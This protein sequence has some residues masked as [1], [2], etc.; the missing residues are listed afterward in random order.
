MKRNWTTLTFLMVLL[1]LLAQGFHRHGKLSP[2]L[3]QTVRSHQ[4]M[5]HRAGDTDDNLTL[6]F[7]QIDGSVT[8]D[9]LATFKARRYAQLDDIAIV[10][11]PL[12]QID[13]FSHFSGVQR[14]EA[15]Q[16]LHAT[17]DTVPNVVDLLAAYQST[18]QHQ[19]YTGKGVVVGLMDVGFD[20]TH[21]TFFT[22]GQYRIGAF[23]D[24]LAP[25][26]GVS[27]NLPVGN[28][29]VTTETLLSKGYATDGLLDH[30]GTHTAG[31]AAG[32]GHDTH[33]RGVAFESDICLVANAVS[34]DTV[35]I[36]K[37]D[38]Y[39]YTS[40]TDA[41]GFKYLFDY[42]ERQ[43]KPCVVSFSEGYMP[44]IDQDDSLY[45]AFLGKLTGPGRILVASAGNENNA[46]TYV[47]KP[48]GVVSAGAFVNCERNT[49]RYQVK[50]DG[51]M[52]I[53]LIIYNRTT[54]ELQQTKILS[55]SGMK[56]DEVLTDKLVVDGQECSLTMDRYPSTANP[57]DTIYQLTMTSPVAF[58]QLADIAIVAVGEESRVEIFG[59]SS[60][61]LRNLPDTDTRWQ[62]AS[63]GHNI[64]APGCFAETICV[65]ATTHRLGYLK[66]S[67]EYI[68]NFD[69][70]TGLLGNYSSTGPALNGLSKPDVAAPGSNVESANSSYFFEA[71]PTSTAYHVA[72]SDVEGRRYPWGVNSGTS[73]ATPVVAG[74]IALWLQ[75]NP[76]LTPDDVMDILSR[77]SKHPEA[78]LSYP[79]MQYGYGEID[80]Y[81]GLLDILQL[82]SVETL[83]Q[84]PSQTVNIGV[85]SDQLL[86]HFAS[87]PHRPVTVSIYSVGGMLVSQTV[88]TSPQTEVKMPLTQLANGI[89][90][91]QLTSAEPGITGS[92]L[93]RK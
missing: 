38:Y 80:G 85:Q 59:S 28:E 31:I 73:M 82:T 32:S 6:V 70:P 40:A 29:Y 52:A 71:H 42:A 79:N 55:M 90:A 65:G 15:S 9:Q 7:V 41:L 22:N 84:H 45:A 66:A 62:G 81:K 4:Q 39:K 46:Q 20:L 51:A 12:S 54:K 10:M 67:G 43:Q 3:R 91:V 24:Q 49:C 77:T 36:D 86:L 63:K 17:M 58:N 35:L 56:P 27:S 21:P 68:K 69:M 74:T 76:S 61:A 19:A 11:L 87:V 93:V 50:A 2:W 16:G 78:A 26:A 44:Y 88:L 1:P 8:D 23:W 25:W 33:F 14:I 18:A 47:E 13:P 83:S 48:R 89:Y 72:Y 30:H 92:A 53:H 5:S 57:N 64:L 60:S 34:A 75:A 37:S